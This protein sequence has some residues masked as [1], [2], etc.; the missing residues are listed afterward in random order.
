MC[1]M[2]LALDEG[3][4]NV[5]EALEARGLMNNTFIIFTSDNGGP[6]HADSYN[7]PLR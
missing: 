2:I 6:V 7:W 1:G 3:V 4:G 5:T